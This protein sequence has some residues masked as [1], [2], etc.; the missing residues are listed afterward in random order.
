MFDKYKSGK[1]YRKFKELFTIGYRKQLRTY[2]EENNNSIYLISTDFYPQYNGSV[3]YSGDYYTVKDF[4]ELSSEN[5]IIDLEN[6]KNIYLTNKKNSEIAAFFEKEKQRQIQNEKSMKYEQEQNKLQIEQ[7]NKHNIINAYWRCVTFL[8]KHETNEKDFLIKSTGFKYSQ[9]PESI[10]LLE[11]IESIEN[12]LYGCCSL[13]QYNYIKNLAVKWGLVI[14]QNTFI[15][16]NDAF[17]FINILKSN[18]IDIHQNDIIK[19][20]FEHI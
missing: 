8:K 5:L 18:S 17:A 6:F 9:N 15:F 10:Y 19:K 2:E 20:Y 1:T 14:K 12:K 11:E 4:I 7:I 3:C 13:K 16:K